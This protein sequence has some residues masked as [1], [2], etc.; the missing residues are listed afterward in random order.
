MTDVPPA[1]WSRPERSGRGPTPSLDREAIAAAAVKLADAEGYEALSMRSLAGALGVGATSLYRYVERKDELLDLMIDA[2]IGAEMAYAPVGRWREDLG[3]FARALRALLLAHPWMAVHGAGRPSMGPHSLD[4]AERVYAS[5]DGLGLDID[6]M[7]LVVRTIDSFVRGSALDE[8][9]E[10]EAIRRS[11]LDQDQWM[12]SQQPWV[13]S[14]LAAGRHP[15]I[16]RIVL[17]ASSPHDPAR[18]DAAF[19]GGLERVLD[20]IGA[21][22]AG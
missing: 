5:I 7:L 19:E 12:R 18:A 9:A 14:I 13:E 11:G 10:R 15:L 1:I 20:G 17:D 22:I 16:A 4:L 8:L 2:T 6:A 21:G 3:A